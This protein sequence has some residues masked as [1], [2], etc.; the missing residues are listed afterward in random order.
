MVYFLLTELIRLLLLQLTQTHFLLLT[1]THFLLLTQ[2]A[3]TTPLDS[4]A[5]NVGAEPITADS[6][7]L[8]VSF[9]LFS[10]VFKKFAI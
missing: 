2:Q 6:P 7:A 4:L 10:G 5:T 3:T 1:Q 9:V 8:Y